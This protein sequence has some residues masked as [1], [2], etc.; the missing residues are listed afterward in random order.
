MVCKQISEAI[1]NETETAPDEADS[2]SGPSKDKG[3]D[4]QYRWPLPNGEQNALVWC[5]SELTTIGE[6][7]SRFGMED[8]ADVAATQS[9]KYGVGGVALASLYAAAAIPVT[10]L[11]TAD[12]IDN[13]WTIVG[14]RAEAVG[15]LLA[16]TLLARHHGARPVTL[17]G[18]SMG[19]RVIFFCLKEL[20]QAG[21]RGRG[22]VEDAILIGA[23][24]SRKSDSWARLRGVVAG[25]LINA[26]STKDY[27][28][29]VLYRYQS[30]ELAVA[31]IAPV[32]AA[33]V[34]NVDISHIVSRHL[35]Y[36]K[37]MP[38]ILR[39]LDLEGRNIPVEDAEFVS[40]GAIADRKADGAKSE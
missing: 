36:R 37:K 39:M 16:Q 5:S 33:G 35:D 25:R 15:K 23:A 8:V 30:W 27:I 29:K 26:Y 11:K 22:I 19:A 24:V 4:E 28:L 40:A 9:I 12:A 7:M 20:N 6:R 13:P 18:F 38:D 17:C 14:E 10:I 31:G 21:D 34:E 1:F 2:D 3:K 32:E